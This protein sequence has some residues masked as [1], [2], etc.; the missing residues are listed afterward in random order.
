MKKVNIISILSATLLLVAHSLLATDIQYIE[1]MQKN[2]HVVYTAQSMAEL[3]E[4]VNALQRIGAAE[5]NKWEP[6]YYASF[7]Y[8]MMASREQDGAKKDSYLDQA[9]AGIEKAKTINGNDSEVVALEGFV[10]MMRITVDPG[11]RGPQYSGLAMQTFGKASAM[12]PDNPRALVLKAQMQFGTSKFFGSP[13]TDACETLDL[14]VTKFEAS[15]STNPL[16]PQ[17]G[18]EMATALQHECN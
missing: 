18:R 9:M 12:N 1:A 4:A 7:G 10:Q 15:A 11:T 2:I 3:Q 17:W 5:K 13:A 6:H 16:A 14:A 8:I